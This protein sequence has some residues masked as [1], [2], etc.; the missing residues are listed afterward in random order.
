MSWEWKAGYPFRQNLE[1]LRQYK[2]TQ[3]YVDRF[4]GAIRDQLGSHDYYSGL[5]N[6]RRAD[7]TKRTEDWEDSA[8]GGAVILES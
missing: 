8:L 5:D 4:I 7:I 2:G 3:S 1:N 6:R